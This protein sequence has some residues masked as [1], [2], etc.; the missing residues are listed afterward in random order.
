M[1]SNSSR[2]TVPLSDV[3]AA[4]LDAERKA[5]LETRLLAGGRWREPLPGLCFTTATGL[6]RNGPT[7][8]HQFERALQRAGLPVIRWRHLRHA[9]AGLMLG[10]G[11]DLATVSGLLGHSSVALT[12]S[13]YAGVMPSLKRGAA[14]RLGLLLQRPG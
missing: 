6:P 13:T 12:A 3:A 1:K 7:L 4:T 9:Y 8:T 5:Q 2:R 10:S 14:D 11:S